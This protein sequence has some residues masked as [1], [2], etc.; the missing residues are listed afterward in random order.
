MSGGGFTMQQP[1]PIVGYYVLGEGCFAMY[2]G[3]AKR[4]SKL[5]RWCMRTLLG[6]K[7]SEGANYVADQS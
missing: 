1:P 5:H 3:M 2:I 7:W 4:P 6:F